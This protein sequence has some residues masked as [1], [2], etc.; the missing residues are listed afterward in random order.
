M[1]E[2]VY[3]YRSIQLYHSFILIYLCHMLF[4]EINAAA[5]ATETV[6]SPVAKTHVK[7]QMAFQHS[8]GR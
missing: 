2:A 7:T 8:A 5:A 1:L 6:E 3:L 4:T